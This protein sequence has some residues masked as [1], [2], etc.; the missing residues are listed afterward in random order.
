MK[1]VIITQSDY[2]PW[3]GYFDAINMV[4]EFIIYD[5]M[6]YTKRDW[7]NRNK[8]KTPNGLKW[9][10]IPVEVKG[11]Y[12][13][14]INETRIN[15]KQW[16]KEHWKTISYNYS[17]SPY[18]KEFK[19]F[20]EE[21]YLASD[22]V[23]LSRINYRFLKAISEMLKIKTNFKWSSEFQ[24]RGNKSE[25]LLNLCIDTGADVYFSG[26]AAKSYLDIELFT[27]SGISVQW[28]DYS[29][30]PE[31]NQLYPPFEHGVTILDLI[32]SVGGN[33]RHYLKSFDN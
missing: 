33:A 23:Y 16:N 22:E 25:K 32:F 17:K 31:Y 8:I 26:P 5:D 1:K 15:D 12:F 2:I 10:T 13:Q 27:K 18:F 3:K 24:L 7:R 9:L 30:Y 28:F 14:R 4:D 29:D 6:Q 20:F 11:K 21:L 19:S